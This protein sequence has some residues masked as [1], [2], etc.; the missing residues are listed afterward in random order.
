[1]QPLDSAMALFHKSNA[2][3]T[4]VSGQVHVAAGPA[5]RA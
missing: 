5:Y 1:M 4:V 3:R 2:K